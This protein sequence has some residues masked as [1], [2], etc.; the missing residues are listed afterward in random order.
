[1]ALIGTSNTIL[2]ASNRDTELVQTH[3]KEFSFRGLR[4]NMTH[5]VYLDGVLTNWAVKPYGKDLGDSLVTDS[6]GNVT[7][8][9]LLEFYYSASYSYDTSLQQRNLLNN[10]NQDNNEVSY[11]TTNRVLE[12]KAPGSYARLNIPVRILVTAGDPNLITPHSH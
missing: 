12:I 5:D 11:N 10:K 2:N 3:L 6:A 9:V 1:M 7:C 8:Y 4:A